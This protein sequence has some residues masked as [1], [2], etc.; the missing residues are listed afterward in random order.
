MYILKTH[1]YYMITMIEKQDHEFERQQGWLY[2][3]GT[4]G[5]NGNMEMI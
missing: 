5:R 4:V 1:I 3:E 2:I